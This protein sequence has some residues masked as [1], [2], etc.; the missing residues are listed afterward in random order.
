MDYVC[1]KLV[2]ACSHAHRIVVDR[3][4]ICFRCICHG[5]RSIVHRA[6]GHSDERECN[7]VQRHVCARNGPLD[8]LHSEHAFEVDDV[9]ICTVQAGRLVESVVVE[10]HLVFRTFFSDAVCHLYGCL[11]VTVKEVDL[12]SYHSHVAVLPAGLFELVVKHIEYGPEDD[13]HVA[14]LSVCDKF[15]KI[16]LRDYSEHVS[17]LRIVPSFVKNDVFYAVFRREVDVM[18]VCVHVDAGNEVDSA[19]SPVVPPVP[20]YLSALDPRC[21]LDAA[22]RCEGIDEVVCRELRVA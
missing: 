10:G 1:R 6:A 19:E 12:E 9:R 8:F 4:E 18:P 16:K 13:V 20:C 21:V 22:W 17:A 2:A 11:V 3:L 5:S 14:V 15:L 7:V